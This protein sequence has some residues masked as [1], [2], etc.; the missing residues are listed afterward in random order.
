[1]EVIASSEKSP[2]GL[3]VEW[4]DLIH[5]RLTFENLRYL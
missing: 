2:T 3:P 4:E 5:S 1:M